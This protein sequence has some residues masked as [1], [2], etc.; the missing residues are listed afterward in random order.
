MFTLSAAS[1]PE[2]DACFALIEQG[3]EFQREQGFVQWTESY[4]QLAHIRADIE[5]G[6]GYV[7][8]NEQGVIAGYVCIDF[9]GEPA[10]E[11][12]KGKWS[13]CAP[14][15]VLH[16]M[17]VSSRFRGCGL[18]SKLLAECERVCLQKGVPY[19]RADT[20]PENTRMQHVFEKCGFVRCG[21]VTFRGADKIAYDKV[22][23]TASAS[24]GC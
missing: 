9:S 7:L 4:P 21:F 8:K 24:V 19:I 3:R 20:S 6:M 22:L 23:K 1:L 18:G 17:A 15:G 2:A 14:C 11:N 10:Y 16:R 12:I 5:A 13:L